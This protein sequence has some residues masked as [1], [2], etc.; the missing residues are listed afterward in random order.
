MVV[1]DPDFI[2]KAQVDKVKHQ[3]IIRYCW[4]GLTAQGFV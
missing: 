3:F 4:A 2:T 1:L